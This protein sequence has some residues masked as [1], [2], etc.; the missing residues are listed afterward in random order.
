MKWPIRRAAILGCAGAV[1]GA[2]CIVGAYSWHP[3][4]GF[5]MDRDP[6]RRVASGFYP[7]ERANDLTFAWTSRRADIK[8]P[9]VNRS[10]EWICAIRLRGARSDPTAQPTV[11]F[12]V[13]GL[14]AAS[15][16]ATNDF[17]DV[18]VVIPARADDEGAVVTVTSSR[19]V[20]PGPSDSRELG[21]QVDRVVCHPAAAI[22]SIP[23]WVTVR[24][25]AIASA[26]FGVAF[27]LAAVP[28]PIAA[29]ATGLVAIVQS[30]PLSSGPAP[31]T[32]FAGDILGFA[33]WIA[34]LA[35]GLLKVLEQLRPGAVP[36]AARVAVMFSA[37]A[38]YVKLLGLLHPSK[39]LIDAVFHAH[40][41]EWVLNGRYF[42]TQT[43]PTGV[44]FPYAIGLYVFAAP[45]AAFTHD[46]VLLLRVVV[47]AA[48]TI[49]GTLLYPLIVK[50]W[51]DRIAAL[52]AVVL[53]STVP[54]V[55]GLVGNANLTNAFGE[56]VG[57]ATIA[58]ASMMPPRN[59]A[60]AGVFLLA[61]LAFLSHISTFALL[62][63]TLT[64]LSALYRWRAGAALH[65]IAWTILAVT[66]LGVLLAVGVYYSH[67]GDVY[68][69]ALRVR[70]ENAIVQP[71]SQAETL[72][73]R[74]EVSTVPPLTRR[75]VDAVSF[76][77]SANGWPLWTLAL[78]GIWR[79]WIEGARDRAAL[80]IYAWGVACAAFLGV[81]VMRVDAPFQRY[82][83]EFF[84]RVL[85]A[86]CP[87]VVMLAARGASWGWRAGTPIRIA[88]VALVCCAAVLGLRSWLAWFL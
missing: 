17:Q 79:S 67:F 45:W 14:V 75:V 11:D 58:C 46:Y 21:V 74:A 25:A 55:Y 81:A 37:A 57:L 19:T 70:A 76:A 52:V 71:Q 16:V 68:R 47:C 60:S 51:N 48:E 85:L 22:V 73:P 88:S 78:I 33:A 43:M 40:R 7:V 56:A 41:F 12:A 6:P 24:D 13:D 86:T 54:L 32:G 84:G 39:L 30:V 8:L 5:D 82:A 59:W 63:V 2:L 34:L 10:R 61:S 28:L 80:A 62:A 35:I 66:I 4:L 77:V 72:G 49:A 31:Y 64:T 36:D 9:G 65:R 53:F 83:T 18:K 23:P 29:A 26:I 3:A 42:F 50:A 15:V 44:S 20:V 27:A 87:A 1:V 69:A 38:L